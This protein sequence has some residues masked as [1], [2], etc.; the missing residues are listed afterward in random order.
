MEERWLL[1]WCCGWCCG[2]GRSPGRA[3]GRVA[4]E[5]T[6]ESEEEEPPVEFMSGESSQKED[7]G[8]YGDFTGSCWW[9]WLS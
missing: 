4:S 2:G 3:L 9:S 5:E 6:D 8:E 7:T 1:E